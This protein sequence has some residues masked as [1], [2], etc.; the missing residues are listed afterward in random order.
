MAKRQSTI[1]ANPLD[2]LL[3]GSEREQRPQREEREK[4][5]RLPHSGNSD[6]SGGEKVRLTVHVP[7][8]VSDRAKNAVFWTPGLTLA[9]LAERALRNELDRIEAERGEPFPNRT[10]ELRGGRPI[11]G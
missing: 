9:D 6:R 2:D 7:V 8:S 4:R 1:G 11:K 10:S 3:G 5:E